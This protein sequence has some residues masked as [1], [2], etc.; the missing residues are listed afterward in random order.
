MP[1]SPRWEERTLYAFLVGRLDRTR[2]Q[3]SP[4]A[5]ADILIDLYASLRESVGGFS[6]LKPFEAVGETAVWGNEPTTV[7]LVLVEPANARAADAVIAEHA[8]RLRTDLL[9]DEVWV[10][11]QDLQLYIAR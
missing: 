3:V 9:Q 8:G 11:K 2:A 7:V 1:Q 6:Y 5:V 10:T 4:E